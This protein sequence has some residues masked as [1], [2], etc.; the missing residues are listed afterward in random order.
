MNDKEITLRKREERKKKIFEEFIQR[1]ETAYR[2]FYTW[3]ALRDA[4]KSDE[5]IR[6]LITTD[7]QLFNTIIV[8]LA[9]SSTF[10]LAKI[11]ET[12]NIIDEEGNTSISIFYLMEYNL[13]DYDIR[14]T[15]RKL[16]KF[17]NKVLGHIDL[18]TFLDLDN[19]LRELDLKYEEIEILF[20]KV[21]LTANSI[22]SIFFFQVDLIG[23]FQS[24]KISCE[25]DIKFLR[26]SV[27]ED[28]RGRTQHIS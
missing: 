22:R 25:E 10:E 17:R 24:V 16:R 20:E 9:F 4:L 11:T 12:K 3:K 1:L 6:F 23:Y 18:K 7:L 26:K 8:S 28:V 21:V 14:E 19:F 2:E 5:N 15:V 27:D 13:S